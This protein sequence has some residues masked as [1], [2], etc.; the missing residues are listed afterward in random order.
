V[1]AAIGLAL[2]LL[3][4]GRPREAPQEHPEPAAATIP[5]GSGG[6]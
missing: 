4:L 5:R 2:A 6:G 3:L 1:L